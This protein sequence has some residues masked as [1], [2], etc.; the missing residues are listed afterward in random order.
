MSVIQKTRR[1]KGIIVF[2]LLLVSFFSVA[3][4]QTTYA[5][6]GS[7]PV[8]MVVEQTFTEPTSSSAADTFTYKLTAK[9]TGNP[10]PSGSVGDV[11][12]FTICGTGSVNAGPISFIQT[13]IY[14]YEIE[15]YIAS[16]KT[17]YTYD[18][19]V[20]TVTVYIDYAKNAVVI[21]QKQDGAKTGSIKFANKYT[22]LASDPSLMVDPL[23]NKTVSGN[24]GK[25]SN[26]TFKLE[27]KDKSNPMPSG[28]SGGVKT[29]TIVGS[30]TEDFGTWSYT[31]IGTYY[32]TVSETNTGERGYI[33]DSMVY[34]ITDSVKDVD[35]QL[36]LTRTVANASGKQVSAFDFINQYS[37]TVGGSGTNGP[38][39]GDDT[40]TGLYQA[41]LGISGLVLM[42]CMVYL[43]MDS[44]R[45]KKGSIRI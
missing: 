31:E 28:S 36:V 25:D 30:G 32:Y 9:E 1:G 10:M 26:F 22:Y 41:I 13:G 11:Y 14:N 35:G 45:K 2:C 38:K 29:L 44:K 4:A 7:N 3:F 23:V 18:A 37:A 33:Y 40:M 42:A 5:A 17:G 43:L 27:A 39:T 21:I 19:Q 8:T 24:P 34:T 6:P 15:Q 16:P 20:Y 12:T